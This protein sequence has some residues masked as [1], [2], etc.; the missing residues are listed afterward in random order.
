[1]SCCDCVLLTLCRFVSRVLLAGE[2]LYKENKTNV[3]IDVDT[4]PDGVRY[5]IKGR[6][7]LQLGVLL[8]T[9]VRELFLRTGSGHHMLP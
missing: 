9:M 5:T 7:E 2:R 1:M 3:A 8:E 6:G 4:S